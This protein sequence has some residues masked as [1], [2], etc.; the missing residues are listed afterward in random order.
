M[1]GFSQSVGSLKDVGGGLLDQALN[2][3]EQ[4]K[5]Q[6]KELAMRP[7]YTMI[8]D[9]L[10]HKLAP[11]L[12]TSQGYS[13][14]IVEHGN[15]ALKHAFVKPEKIN[16]LLAGRVAVKVRQIHIQSAHVKIPWFAWHEGVEVTLDTLYVIVQPLH[17]ENWTLDEVRSAREQD[18]VRA[19]KALFKKEAQA[20][21]LAKMAKK[22]AKVEKPHFFARFKAQLLTTPI[23]VKVSNVHLRYE[24]LDEVTPAAQRFAAGL[25]L[26]SLEASKEHDAGKEGVE[27]EIVKAELSA[28][29][30]CRIARAGGGEDTARNMIQ[31]GEA[32]AAAAPRERAQ[33]QADGASSGRASPEKQAPRG[34][35]EA[36]EAMAAQMRDLVERSKAWG[37]GTWLVG[38]IALSASM[39]KV[40]GSALAA[41]KGELTKLKKAVQAGTPAPTVS[42]VPRLHVQLTLPPF[43]VNVTD[44]QLARFIAKGNQETLLKLR[45]AYSLKRPR[46]PSVRP[47]RGDGSARAYW[48]SAIAAV[49]GAYFPPK[50]T[51]GS[52][53]KQLMARKRRYVELVATHLVPTD[54]DEPAEFHDALHA[55]PDAAVRDEIQAIEDAVP[56]KLLAWWR[57]ASLG[58]SVKRHPEAL[59]DVK[60]HVEG[61]EK[62]RKGD[63]FG[64]DLLERQAKFAENLL[65]AHEDDKPLTADEVLEAAA[66]RGFLFKV[67]SVRA[68]AVA[69]RLLQ[70]DEQTNRH[71]ELLRFDAGG[72]HVRSR[73]LAQLGK[74]SHVV[75]RAV[76]ATSEL[77]TPPSASSGGEAATAGSIATPRW[78]LLRIQGEAVE[79]V[80]DA[81]LGGELLAC[82]PPSDTDA[83]ADGGERVALRVIAFQVPKEEAPKKGGKAPPKAKAAAAVAKVRDVSELSSVDVAVDGI[84]Y[85][86]AA[87]FWGLFARFFSSVEAEMQR[88]PAMATSPLRAKYPK[89]L[90]GLSEHLR[91]PWWTADMKGLTA[92]VSSA[93]LLTSANA[94]FPLLRVRLLRG[95]ALKLD[96]APIEC[97]AARARAEKTAVDDTTKAW[98]DITKLA[99]AA[100]APADWPTTTPVASLM[101]M[102]VPPME[103]RRSPK[104]G[105]DVAEVQSSVRFAE[106]IIVASPRADGL[107]SRLI[108][109]GAVAR[110]TIPLDAEDVLLN[111]LG[112]FP[113][114]VPPAPILAAPAATQTGG[115]V[116]RRSIVTGEAIDPTLPAP[117]RPLSSAQLSRLSYYGDGADA[118]PR[119]P[120]HKLTPHA[121]AVVAVAVGGLALLLL[122]LWDGLATALGRNVEV[123]IW[124]AAAPYPFLVAIAAMLLSS[125]CGAAKPPRKAAT[126]EMM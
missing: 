45:A 105:G 77:M 124:V 122:L 75:V 71:R 113:V 24:N 73:T 98:R 116:R 15:I 111:C 79:S 26:H 68:D 49:Q 51:R 4:A 114:D 99:M 20:A 109:E 52:A 120:G 36:Q 89:M 119:S 41:W 34:F 8:D 64:F 10:T 94:G 101:T 106:Q 66:P 38:P 57:V 13:D 18:I 80:P 2:A 76:A 30:Y 123:S 7:F 17:K 35:F 50:S 33:T 58:A 6:A 61:H 103:I 1:R 118:A 96:A 108:S 23:R 97:P 31:D 78:C 88:S 74:R 125:R 121:L 91:R 70:H 28:G 60:V 67:I 59:K 37:S 104:P 21:K 110:G 47:R 27:L 44:E 19:V 48:R 55:L 3:G 72:V 85:T 12:E 54:L 65:P 87:A 9:L 14:I 81:L 39:Q 84:E 40:A 100:E 63:L 53:F 16:E 90:R 102:T 11:F 107:L 86:Y 25:V 32:A 43:G 126:R 115:A 92:F 82:M 93:A 29:A 117:Q 5:E 56:V 42:P 112:R 62:K 83:D 95:V 69:A 46:D 22:D